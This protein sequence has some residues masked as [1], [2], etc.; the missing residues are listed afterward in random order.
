MASL[1]P[2]VIPS[3]LPPSLIQEITFLVSSRP[4]S[5]KHTL[6][7]CDLSSVWSP[8]YSQASCEVDTSVNMR[9]SLCECL[10]CAVCAYAC[11]KERAIIPPL[12]L[13]ISCHLISCRPISDQSVCVGMCVSVKQHMGGWVANEHFDPDLR[14]DQLSLHVYYLVI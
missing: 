13:R 3:T 11:V 6:L 10:C 1:P 14:S 4:H 12:A 7:C 2:P 5:L 8:L 9:L